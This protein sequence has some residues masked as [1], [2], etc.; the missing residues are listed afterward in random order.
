LNEIKYNLAWEK[1]EDFKGASIYILRYIY[2]IRRD[3]MS[4]FKNTSVTVIEEPYLQRGYFHG[5]DLS[6]A[7]QVGFGTFWSLFIAEVLFR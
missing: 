7:T 5:I 3:R 4:K 1:I 2:K 6:T